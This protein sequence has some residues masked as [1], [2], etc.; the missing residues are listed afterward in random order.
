[1]FSACFLYNKRIPFVPVNLFVATKIV[2][3]ITKKLGL[4][5][6]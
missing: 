4:L 5:A 2:V 3:K 6:N 1:M